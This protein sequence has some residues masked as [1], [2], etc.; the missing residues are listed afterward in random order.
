MIDTDRLKARLR[1]RGISQAE[2]ARRVGLRQ[3]TI[4]LLFNGKSQNTTRLRDIARELRTTA[5]YLEGRT[6]DPDSQLADPGI[7]NEERELIE[8]T[9]T[10]ARGDLDV[11][12]HLIRRLAS[13]PAPG[14][15]GAINDTVS[16]VHDRQ[17][18]YRSG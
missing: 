8:L 3:S 18:G 1:A 16:T 6:D 5:E 7:S 13:C 17:L 15:R 12:S 11:V 2:L 14:L 4:N 10:L 9:R